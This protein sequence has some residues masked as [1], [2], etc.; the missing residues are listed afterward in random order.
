V[1][2]VIVHRD[3]SLALHEAPTPGSRWKCGDPTAKDLGRI[4]LNPIPSSTRS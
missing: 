3:L 1:F 2:V 4:T